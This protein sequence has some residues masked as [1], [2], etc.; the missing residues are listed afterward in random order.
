MEWAVTST[1]TG[2]S[3]VLGVEDALMQHDRV[4]GD[5]ASPVVGVLEARVVE[6]AVVDRA[7]VAQFF[8]AVLA[9]GE[10]HHDVDVCADADAAE[11]RDVGHEQIQHAG[12][13]RV[14]G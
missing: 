7:A 14:V 13:V 3:A 10:R 4:L 1:L 6:P 2:A 11:G 9:H 5:V 12:A 8:V